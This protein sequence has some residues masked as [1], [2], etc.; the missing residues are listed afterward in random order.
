M[1]APLTS[2][3]TVWHVGTLELSDRTRQDS[4]EGALLSVSQHPEAWGHIAR[5]GGQT[6]EMHREGA[7]W[8]D[9]LALSDAQ[10]ADI[11][12]WAVKAGFA[13]RGD[14]WRV[15]HYDGEADDWG[16]FEFDNEQAALNEL[17][18]DLE[19]EDV[20]SES[21]GQLDRL[22]GLLLTPAGQ[23]A[24]GRWS[25]TTQA[26][27]PIIMLWAETCLKPE[28]PNLMGVWWY[29]DNNPL[30]L[31]CPRGGAFTD[32]LGEFSISDELG[33]EPPQS[34]RDRH[35]QTSNLSPD[36]W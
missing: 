18:P 33:R 4:L 16:Y 24:V 15:W 9:A 26:L 35:A 22:P 34:F 31:S 30:S 19:D 29:E 10:I 14:V 36:S 6:W 17:D 28:N 27:D 21:G 13:V 23:E 20:P 11:E 32:R 1:S 8:L 12:D 2:I 3:D 5:C 7:Q 25:D